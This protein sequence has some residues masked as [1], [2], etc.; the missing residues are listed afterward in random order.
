MPSLPRA[1]LAAEALRR[2]RNAQPEMRPQER[3]NW[4]YYATAGEVRK[5]WRKWMGIMPGWANPNNWG[6]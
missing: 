1:N 5:H 3:D 4:L 2:Y 6:G